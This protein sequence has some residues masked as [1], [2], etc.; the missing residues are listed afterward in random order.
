MT[1]LITSPCLK[2]QDVYL[3]SCGLI[4][5]MTFLLSTIKT[6]ADCVTF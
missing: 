2:T 6:F 3:L 1:S 5:A 4:R